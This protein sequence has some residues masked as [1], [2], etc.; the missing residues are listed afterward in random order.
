MAV[1]DAIR[2]SEMVLVCFIAREDVRRCELVD[3]KKMV[4]FVGPEKQSP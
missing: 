3:L 4:A 1:I 2:T